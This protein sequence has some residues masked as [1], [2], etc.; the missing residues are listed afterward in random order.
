MGL[1]KRGKVWHTQFCV[2]GQRFRQ[3]LET[4]DWREAQRR[5]KELISRA[6]QGVLSPGKHEFAQLGFWEGGLAYLASRTELALSSQQKERQ[7]LVKPGAFFS[8]RK[9]SK[10]KAQDILAFRDW[11]R[12]VPDPQ[13]S[14]WR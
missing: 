13:S 5:E 9:L 12:L 11:R 7:L 10:I 3:S 4:T 6:E 1:I 8:Q 2:G 14:I